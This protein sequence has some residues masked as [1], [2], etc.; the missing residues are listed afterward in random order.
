LVEADVMTE[1]FPRWQATVSYRT[2]DGP[3]EVEHDIA[4]LTD[5]DA[6][7]ERGPHWGTVIG[8]NVVPVGVPDLTIEQAG[9][10]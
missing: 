1:W 4:E 6:L 8:I 2:N 7:V 5:L 3:I 9:E 10:L